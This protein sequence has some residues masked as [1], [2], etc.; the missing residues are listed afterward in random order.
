[1]SMRTLGLTFDTGALIALERRTQRMWEIYRTAMRDAIPITV[2]VAVVVEWWRGRTDV[3]E[4]ILNGLRVEPFSLVLAQTAG[5]ALAAIQSASA[6]DAV[7]MASAATR[8]DVVYT[9]DIVDLERLRRHFPNVRVL[10]V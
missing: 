3:R 4:R 9:S 1:M 5:E 7:V 6:I 8:G 2:P 10:S